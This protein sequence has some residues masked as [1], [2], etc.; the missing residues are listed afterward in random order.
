MYNFEWFFL[1]SIH[2]ITITISQFYRYYSMLLMLWFLFNP[3]RFKG[4]CLN[5]CKDVKRIVVI[6]HRWIC[7]WITV[8]CS[9]SVCPEF[10]TPRE[11]REF[12]WPLKWCFPNNRCKLALKTR[13]ALST[14][15]TAFM[16]YQTTKHAT[17]SSTKQ[18]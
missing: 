2:T 5:I 6:N 1:L 3:W 15:L 9:S 7:A 17:L 11:N 4:S 16:S 13:E 14:Q 12:A 8:L 18:C 10:F